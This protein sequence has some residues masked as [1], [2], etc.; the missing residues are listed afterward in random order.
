[1]SYQAE[2]CKR[3]YNRGV[4]TKEML[5]T[6]VTKGKITGEEYALITGESFNE[7]EGEE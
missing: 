2:L 5:Q 1:M 4:A 7:G 6:L 3:Q